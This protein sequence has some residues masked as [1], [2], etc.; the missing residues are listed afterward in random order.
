MKIILFWSTFNDSNIDV[1]EWVN[2]TAKLSPFHFL[3]LKSHEKFGNEVELY[4][5]QKIDN[6][7]IPQNIVIKN[8][9]NIFPAKYAHNALMRGH[10]IAHIADAVRL[11]VASE[12]T[13]VVL[14]MD[15]VALK[16]FPQGD[17][18]GWFASMPAKKTGGFA[19]KWG[20]SHP[21]L[22][23]HDQSWDGKQLG[24][25]PI[26]VNTVT[27]S[28]I[29]NLSNKILKTLA[30]NPSKNSNAWNYVIWTLKDI[31][32]VNKNLTIY[33]PNIFCPVP[34]WLLSGK[35][36]SLE[37]PSRLDGQHK[38]FGYTLPAIDT[39]MNS[40]I[41][42]QHFFESAFQ[43]SSQV[44]TDFWLTVKDGSLVSKEAQFILGENWK[45]ELNDYA[46]S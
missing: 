37:S 5:Y 38:L 10:S 30:S 15:A 17:D 18:I 22:T 41:T 25:F 24:A 40:S 28:H 43:K 16:E 32:K 29:N 9:D 45:R 8:A 35:C 31:M 39:I 20:K 13:A 44:K 27:K 21:P 6:K 42:V 3:T 7:N 14:D 36:Y 12:K 19:P 26:K 33:Q 23:I 11:K 1:N 34:S 4:T 2:S 46:K